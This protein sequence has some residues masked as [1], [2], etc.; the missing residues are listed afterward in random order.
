MPHTSFVRTKTIFSTFKNSCNNAAQKCR[1]VI[2]DLVVPQS[3]RCAK[4]SKQFCT[5]CLIPVLVSSAHS[6]KREVVNIHKQQNWLKR[7]SLTFGGNAVGLVM[8]MS[9]TRIIENFVEVRGISNLWG[10]MAARPVVSDT[11]YEILSFLI[12]FVVA[13]IV[14]TVAEHYYNVFQQRHE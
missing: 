8:A 3:R 14:F 2:D 7:M 10:L 12:E 11:T 4:L 5:S 6:F 1:P 9:S 13:L